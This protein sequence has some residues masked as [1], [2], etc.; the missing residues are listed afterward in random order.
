MSRESG[1]EH[2][3]RTVAELLAQYGGKAEEAAPARRR[4][5]RADE[6]S[7]TAPQT[8]IDRVLSDSGRMLPI[9]DDPAEETSVSGPPVRPQQAPAP[10]QTPQPPQAAVQQPIRPPQAPPPVAPPPGAPAQQPS[11]AQPL[12]NR[13]GRP[14][15]GRTPPPRIESSR[16]NLSRSDLG[17]R[18]PQ[19]PPPGAPQGQPPAPQP[20]GYFRPVGPGGV[21]NVGDTTQHRPVPPE[22]GGLSARLAGAPPES[23]TEQL[24][25]ITEEPPQAPGRPQPRRPEAVAESTQAH[26]G[27]LV[28]T[29]EHTQAHPG[30]LLDEDEYD[31]AEVTPQESTQ[32]HPGPYVDGEYEE[33]EEDYEYAEGDAFAGYSVAPDAAPAGVDAPLETDEESAEEAPAASPGREWL[34][35]A[36]QLGVGLVGGAALWLGFQLLWNALPAAALAAAVAVIIG[37][38]I[39]VRKIRKADDLQTMVLAVLVGL[40]VTVSPAVLLLVGH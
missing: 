9:R 34:M 27:P 28:D 36:V 40:I 33:Y 38:V 35:M 37:L 24:P 31:S 10:P 15:P 2:T 6:P 16:T 23:A 25:R 39:V 14:A 21:D 3:Q 29:G 30:P 12:P 20:T 1:S 7:E 22:A 17:P 19:G 4:R 8:I 32:A 11:G 13:P 18:P 5:R 26:P